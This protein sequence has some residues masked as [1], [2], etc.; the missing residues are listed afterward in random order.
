M[1]YDVVKAPNKIIT[2]AKLILFKSV[3]VTICNFL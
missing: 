2:S 1:K 3:E